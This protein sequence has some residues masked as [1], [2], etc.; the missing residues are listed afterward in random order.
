MNGNTVSGARTGMMVMAIVAACAGG[1]AQRLDIASVLDKVDQHNPE[2][3]AKERA[4]AAA[5]HR[6]DQA[7]IIPNPE[8]E[9]ETE[10]LGMSEVEVVVSQP[11]ELG[12]KRKRRVAIAKLRQG[13]AA[14]E[15]AGT[16]LRVRAE[17]L[18]RSHAVLAVHD[19]II[20]LDTLLALA[21]ADRERIE[22]RIQA[23]ASPELD[24]IRANVAIEEIKMRKQ[25]LESQR[26]SALIELALLWGDSSGTDLELA[27]SLDGELP[28]VDLDRVLAQV[29]NHP[30]IRIAQQSVDLSKAELA[31]ARAEAFPE[32]AVSGGYLRN[33]EQGENAAILG[34]SI[35]LPLFNRNQGA[36]AAKSEG[37]NATRYAGEAGR[38]AVRTRVRAL[39]S[40]MNVLARRIDTLE[41]TIVPHLSDILTELRDYYQRGLVGILDVLEAR[42]ELAEKEMQAVDLRARWSAKAADLMKI[43]GVELSIAT[44]N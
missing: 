34:L 2:I 35:G 7:G 44:T 23:G 8:L 10:N 12:G 43:A 29:P 28:K 11:L 32:T 41:K 36:I 1:P 13:I 40:E 21:L 5:G 19:R 20:A 4:L 24:R 6:V 37:V 25:A 16:R 15:L 14:D 33:N 30:D 38:L 22:Q 27:G 39:V 3:Q 18:R 31:R 26:E 17:A 9:V 42:N